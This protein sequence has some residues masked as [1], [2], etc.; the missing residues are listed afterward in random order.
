[1]SIF[2]NEQAAEPSYK[3]H[4]WVEN[5]TDY[6]AVLCSVVD[7]DSWSLDATIRAFQTFHW[8]EVPSHD[9]LTFV[10][11]VTGV[12]ILYD[13]GVVAVQHASFGDETNSNKLRIAFGDLFSTLAE[14]GWTKAVVYHPMNTMTALLRD[15]GSAVP[16]NMN[17][18]VD[19]ADSLRDVTNSPEAALLKK[20]ARRLSSLDAE[21]LQAVQSMGPLDESLAGQNPFAGM[22]LSDV[23]HSQNSLSN[24]ISADVFQQSVRSSSKDDDAIVSTTPHVG[25]T[26][27]QSLDHSTDSSATPTFENPDVALVLKIESLRGE[28]AAEQQSSFAAKE[29][30]QKMASFASENQRL[31]AALAL[32]KTTL[33][34]AKGELIQLGSSHQTLAEKY[35]LLGLTHA[36][37][38]SLL[39]AARRSSNVMPELAKEK[40]ALLSQVASLS[41]S[42]VSANS[43]LAD[44]HEKLAGF[45][46]GSASGAQHLD[47]VMMVGASAF[48]FDTP[49]T[50]LAIS[51]VDSLRELTGVQDVVHLSPGL[52]GQAMRWDVMDEYDKDQP[53]LLEQFLYSMG[54]PDVDI[55]AVGERILSVKETEAFPQLRDLLSI[56]ECRAGIV[57]LGSLSLCAAGRAFVDMRSASGS[58]LASEMEAS[59]SVREIAKSAH[60]TL[61]VV[62]VDSLDGPFVGWLAELLRLWVSNYACSKR[63]ALAAPVAAIE[64]PAEPEPEPQFSK[65][66]IAAEFQQALGPLMERLRS[67]GV[68]V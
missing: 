44:A 34:A 52:A 47:D 38:V 57:D 40:V 21:I 24:Q 9:S 48:C 65:E 58:D 68:S 30:V 37:T 28:L 56:D 19:V 46:D 45:L 42:L 15:I 11:P 39:D 66:Q 5:Y 8:D 17:F 50:P 41:E 36:E 2:K 53:W 23:G 14:L 32:E 60:K 51:D 43:E 59:F 7:I 29:A 6:E 26:N 61:Y 20:H 13:G 49:G 3:A 33:A 1:M 27:P 4:D 62:H 54:L 18:E 67:M 35:S 16:A 63:F 31:A 55:V 25:M 12:S 10:H 22:S 64:L